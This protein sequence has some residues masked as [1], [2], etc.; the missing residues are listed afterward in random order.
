MFPGMTA[1]TVTGIDVLHGFEQE[2]VFEIYGD[3]T[4]IRD[5]LVKDYPILIRLSDVRMS[6]DYVESVGYGFHRLGDI[7]GVSN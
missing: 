1:G 2:L 6:P 7:G 4:I 5:M 3:S